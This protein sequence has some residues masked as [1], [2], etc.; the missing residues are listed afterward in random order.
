RI[1][2]FIFVQMIFDPFFEIGLLVLGLLYVGDLIFDSIIDLIRVGQEV[3]AHKENEN[4]ISE[5]VKQMYS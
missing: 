1:N 4:E 3:E 5:I 2:N